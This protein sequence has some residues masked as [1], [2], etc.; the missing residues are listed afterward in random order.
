MKKM[1]DQGIRHVSDLDEAPGAYK[2]IDAVM[3]AQ[4]DLVD[5]I[6]RLRPLAVL[7]GN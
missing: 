6:V 5:R 3:E 7:K 4:V 2:D 1:D